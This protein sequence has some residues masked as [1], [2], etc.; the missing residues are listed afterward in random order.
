MSIKIVYVEGSDDLTIK[1]FYLYREQLSNSEEMV[2]VIPIGRMGYKESEEC[3]TNLKLRS[4]YCSKRIVIITN[5]VTLLQKLT[6]DGAK[7]NGDE[8]FIWPYFNYIN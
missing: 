8:L 7:S 2:S 5:D 3:F 4:V 1:N 6:I